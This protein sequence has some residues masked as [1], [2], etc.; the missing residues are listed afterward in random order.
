V[1]HLQIRRLQAWL[2]ESAF[3]QR[4]LV[5]CLVT[6]ALL[7]IPGIPPFVRILAAWL[8]VCL[9]PGFLIWDAVFR[10]QSA[11][12]LEALPLCFA[13]SLAGLIPVTVLGFLLR[14][15]PSQLALVFYLSLA[16]LALA[17]YVVNRRRSPPTLMLFPPDTPKIFTA[18]LLVTLGV[19]LLLIRIG[20]YWDA[21]A[22]YHLT[23]AR[24]VADGNA[25]DLSQV[26]QGFNA[27]YAY[28]LWGIAVALIARVASADIFEVWYYMPAIL[29]P[30]SVMAVYY[31]AYTLFP[32]FTTASAAGLAYLAW[33]YY[34]GGQPAL[35]F[36][37]LSMLPMPDAL[38]RLIL[39]P[40][41]L[42]IALRWSRE[43]T[44]H[45]RSPL[46]LV[47]LGA[48]LAAIHNSQYFYALALLSA[49]S[50]M[51]AVIWR[52]DWDA[53]AKLALLI[54][55]SALVFVG[56]F[57]FAKW[58]T[59][60][61]TT[62]NPL[63][64]IEARNLAE[65]VD[66][67]PLRHAYPLVPLLSWMLPAALVL[68]LAGRE[69]TQRTRA[70]FILAGLLIGPTVY[71]NTPLLSL[72]LKTIP[73]LNR[74]AIQ[75][76]DLMIPLIG[77]W[78]AVT[79]FT[80]LDAGLTRLGERSRRGSAWHYG[81]L[82]AASGLLGLAV[83]WL[84]SPPINWFGRGATLTLALT[85]VCLVLAFLAALLSN[86]LY[87]YQ[88][89]FR[90]KFAFSFWGQGVAWVCAATWLALNVIL[91]GGTFLAADLAQGGSWAVKAT[92]PVSY[93]Q[94]PDWWDDGLTGF[95]RER[96]P[97]GSRVLAECWPA[98]YLGAL[99]PHDFQYDQALLSIFDPRTDL[100][101]FMQVLRTSDI[102]YILLTKGTAVN[103]KC[104]IGDE[105]GMIDDFAY[106]EPVLERYPAVF[107]KVYTSPSNV[108]WRIVPP[109]ADPSVTSDYWKSY[110]LYAA[111]G[112]GAN[113]LAAL[114]L[115]TLF[116]PDPAAR[117]EALRLSTKY[118]DFK[119]P[120]A[121]KNALHTDDIA[122][123]QSGARVVDNVGF[124]TRPAYSPW[125]AINSNR[126]DGF[127][128]AYAG[129]DGRLECPAWITI[130]LGQPR[131]I[132][133]VG[134]EWATD[135][136][137]RAWQLDY[138]EGDHWQRLVDSSATDGQSRF[139]YDLPQTVSASQVRLTLTAVA[140]P[141]LTGIRRLSLY[142]H[143]GFPPPGT[144]IA[145]LSAGTTVEDSSPVLN[146]RRY[147]IENAIDGNELDGNA[148]VAGGPDQSYPHWFILNFNQERSINALEIQWYD[149]SY[150]QDWLVSY[151]D[152]GGWHPLKEEQGWQPPAD[153]LYRYVLPQPIKAS[154]IR[155]DVNWAS[156]G[157]M[158]VRR[159]SVYGE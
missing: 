14:L 44:W 146:P 45:F 151:F 62:S 47:C 134:I 153:Y 17:N 77:G 104:D 128:A 21:D 5:V 60:S 31:L 123:L 124:S 37:M 111:K 81:G 22:W 63:A 119:Q 80:L 70:T 105:R 126:F 69:Q 13:L 68:F 72:A 46:L 43:H 67:D 132:K 11:N 116:D 118:V 125:T 48:P 102:D 73:K 155:L 89:S 117:C 33:A 9:M 86:P 51:Y 66:I 4:M 3:W 30:L 158:V 65:R 112:D 49:F 38:S 35:S 157:R 15:S 25:L 122:A 109:R 78:G 56:G 84:T 12:L 36:Y 131:A 139:N 136:P 82:L 137:A 103:G 106:L 57:E 71:F 121:G 34:P 94:V 110:E 135:D 75:V 97:G 99:T 154:K 59:N 107:E 27:S 23:I 50:V 98:W 90:S 95:L 28:P 19:A 6:S 61:G 148:A 42:S 58:L 41:F 120:T 152:Q 138:R 127:A 74:F 40:L 8:L 145:L 88:T 52:R 20:P 114:Q 79:L 64:I 24:A 96:V 29:T 83:V 150:G 144:D 130:D 129:T 2:R 91:P 159:L 115:W 10:T 149:K 7:L 156:G 142:E 55:L 16:A 147:R 26:S 76:H 87:P 93:S 141:G 108:V 53:V 1:F 101:S 39:L 133:A 143:P 18:M 92:V 32:S 140:G 54:T 100:P 85:G 113:A